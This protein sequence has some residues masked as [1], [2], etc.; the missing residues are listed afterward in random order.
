MRSKRYV[1]NV[2]AAGFALFPCRMVDVAPFLGEGERVEL[3]NE[4]VHGTTTRDWQRQL[5]LALEAAAHCTPDIARQAGVGL[6]G[7]VPLC[8]V[9]APTDAQFTREAPEWSAAIAQ[10]T[11]HLIVLSGP[12]LARGHA[13]LEYTIAHE[14]AHLALQARIGEMGW[15]PLWLHEG[16]A[17]TWSRRVGIRERLSV[18]GRGPIRLG[19]LSYSFP[20]DPARAHLAYIESAAAARRLLALGPLPA[21]LDR[22]RQGQE[23]DVAFR[24]VYGISLSDFE[25]QVFDEVGRTTRYVGLLTS[26]VTLFALLGLAFII[27]GVQRVRRDRRRRREWEAAEADEGLPPPV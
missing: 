19:E 4:F 3:A 6:E 12:Q 10:P 9:V 18:L 11:R 26:S 14:L 17:V 21:L 20:R 1:S 7:L 15:I 22:V 24:L 23:F 13:D 25:Q 8:I 2:I 16:L 5:E 27:A